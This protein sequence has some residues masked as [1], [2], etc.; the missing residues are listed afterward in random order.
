MNKIQLKFIGKGTGTNP[1][2]AWIAL[3]THGIDD[4][5]TILLSATCESPEAVEFEAN[6]IKELLDKVVAQAKHNFSH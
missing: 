1:H 2:R 4:D 6:Q 3:G 5:G